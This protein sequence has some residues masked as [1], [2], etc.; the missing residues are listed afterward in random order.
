MASNP[1]WCQPLGVW[2][3]YFQDWVRD[4]APQHLLYSAIY[5]DLRP[6]AGEFRLAADLRQ[7]IHA[8][9]SAW[10]SFPRQ[11]ATL[12]VS[13]APPL[14]LFGRFVLGRGEGRRGIDLKLGGVLL[15][16]NALRAYAIDLG[17]DETNTIERL[18][19]AVRAGG[20]FTEDEAEG[21]RLA[22]ETI[23]H[24]RLRHQLARMAAGREPDNVIA[25]S[26]LGRADQRRL[27]D[28]FRDIRRLQGK[29]EDRYFTEALG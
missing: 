10:R 14:G 11:L 5:F 29:I 28:A 1:R 20:C 4:P 17:L 27:K 21:V 25:P 16:V 23:A 24:F 7:E 13:H 18:E 3:G 9:V 26:T 22:Y 12:A 2:R 6:V 8:Q 19:A 15:L